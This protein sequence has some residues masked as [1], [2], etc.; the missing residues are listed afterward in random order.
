MVGNVAHI[1][2]G[3]VWNVVVVWM[4][5]G[6]V[7]ASLCVG[8]G[9]SRCRPVI[10]REVHTGDVPGRVVALTH[11][12]S[13]L[14]SDTTGMLATCMYLGHYNVMIFC[15]SSWSYLVQESN[16]QGDGGQDSVAKG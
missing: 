13:A 7:G 15:N 16:K 6:D 1:L 14:M 2:L 8:G 11:S 12:Y 10:V 5:I 3:D 9:S 4:L